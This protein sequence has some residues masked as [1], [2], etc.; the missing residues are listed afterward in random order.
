MMPLKEL[1]QIF[2]DKKTFQDCLLDIVLPHKIMVDAAVVMYRT[3]KEAN[4]ILNLFKDI[5]CLIL[6]KMHFYE[7]RKKIYEIFQHQLTLTK[8][9][10]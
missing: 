4:T 8:V 6:K 3:V 5:S 9:R 2:Y 1:K 7:R 10:V